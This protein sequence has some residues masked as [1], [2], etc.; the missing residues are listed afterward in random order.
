MANEQKYARI[1]H[2][3][4]DEVDHQAVMRMIRGSNLPYVLDWT[5]SLAGALD[6]IKRNNYD[7]LLLDYHL[8]DGTGLELLERI[9]GIPVI[10]IT[11]RGDAKTAVKAMKEGAY[12]YLFKDIGYGSLEFLPITIEKTLRTFRLEQEHKKYEEQIIRQNA[13]LERLNAELAKMYEEMRNLSL[14]DPLTGIANRRRMDIELKG[15]MARAKR[16]GTPISVV[17]MDI[18]RFKEYNDK[19]GHPAGDRMLAEI[20]ETVSKNVRDVDIVARYGGEEFLIM[21]S[22]TDITGA[23]IMA[24][25]IRKIIQEKA[26]VTVSL[27]VASFSKEMKKEEELSRLRI[28][29]SIGQNKTGETGWR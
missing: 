9:K 14:H 3:E 2:V 15:C 22:D 20:A 29:P 11:G 7:L 21:L 12:D 24:E 5:A 4:D 27:G 28:M 19:Y 17:M 8:P 1:L 13:E 26:G 18:D 23:G 16:Y 25:R 10:F 6:K